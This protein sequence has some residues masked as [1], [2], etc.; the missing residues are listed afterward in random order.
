MK[1]TVGMKAMGWHAPESGMARVYF[2][3][4]PKNR[5]TGHADA[6]PNCARF[7]ASD[8]SI[9]LA[10]M[11]SSLQPSSR[12]CFCKS[13]CAV[14]HVSEVYNLSYIRCSWPVMDDFVISMIL[15]SQLRS[16]GTPPH[17][18]TSAPPHLR[19]P[20]SELGKSPLVSSVLSPLVP[21]HSFL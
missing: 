15:P 19:T 13:L 2:D 14:I 21:L 6:L 5:Y 12:L 16:S 8:Q 4:F 18:R 1:L 17:L 7:M 3:W 20:N 10:M 11:R 9:R